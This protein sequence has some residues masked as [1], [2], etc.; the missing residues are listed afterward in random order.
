MTHE[1]LEGTGHEAHDHSS[2]HDECVEALT[3]L[4][5]FLHGEL[6]ET[7]ADT[8]R[9]HLQ[10]CE[11]CLDAFDVE[12][13]ISAIIKRCHQPTQAPASLRMRITSIRITKN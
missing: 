13:A 10:A 7:S 1:P 5:E 6:D 12:N 9:Q 11:S 2:A 3:R 8:I 4:Q